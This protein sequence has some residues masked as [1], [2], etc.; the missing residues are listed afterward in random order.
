MSA[1]PPLELLPM[2]AGAQEPPESR[3]LRRDA[4]RLMVSRPGEAPIHAC[5]ADLPRFLGAGDLVVINTSATWPAALDTSRPDGVPLRIHLASSLPDGSWLVEPREPD[6]AASHPFDGDLAGMALPLAEGG[7]VDVER[8]FGDS[9]RLWTAHLRVAGDVAGYLARWGRPIRYAYVT[10]EWPIEAYQTVYANAPGS[11]EMP[12]AGRPF[13]PELVTALVSA[14]IG[15]APLLLHT[16]VSSLEG[17]E[18][19]HPEWYSVGT[20]TARL[21][22]QTRAA[23]HRVVAVGTTVVRALESAVAGDGMVGQ[24]SGWTGLVVTSERGVV[25]VDALLTGLHDP[26][27][28]HLEMLRAFATDDLLR[29]A[30]GSARDAGYLWHEFGDSHL[31]FHGV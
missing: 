6:G 2:G 26:R 31:V 29:Q 3:G 7:S 5:F 11:A 10:T 27:A 28:S 4:V 16:G 30:Y 22:N 18:A 20:E 21:V 15:V 1:Q 9:Q 13:S 19:P 8:R 17:D 12:S 23:G 25:T 14:G 24:S